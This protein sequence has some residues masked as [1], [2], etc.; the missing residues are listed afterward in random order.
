LSSVS[1]AVI[2][3][4]KTVLYSK[5]FLPT[6]KKLVIINL[7]AFKYSHPVIKGQWI[8]PST[9]AGGMAFVKDENRWRP[10]LPKTAETEIPCLTYCTVIV[11]VGD[12]HEN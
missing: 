7:K 4:K 2:T 9:F 11:R 8:D 12:M 10:N 1:L 6:L 3:N 5:L